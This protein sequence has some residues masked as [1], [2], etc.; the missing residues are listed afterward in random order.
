MSIEEKVGQLLIT[1]V[2]G[3]ELNDES[4]ALIKQHRIGGVIFAKENVIGEDQTKEFIRSFKRLSVENSEVPMFFALSETGG[5]RSVFP[6]TMKATQSPE[7]IGAIGD[8]EQAYTAGKQIADNMRSLGFNLNFAPVANM[9]FGTSDNEFEE[10]IFAGE[11]QP[12]A[13]MV[14]KFLQGLQEG[15]VFSAAKYFPANAEPGNPNLPA[16][17]EMLKNRE[18]VPFQALAENN[19]SM[20]L[21]SHVFVQTSDS[22]LPIS[23]SEKAKEELLEGFNYEGILIADDITKPIVADKFGIEQSSVMAIQSGCDMI[24]V[25]D[26]SKTA[27]VANRLVKAVNAGEISTETMNNAVFKV[28]MLKAKL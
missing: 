2:N 21:V 23:L 26:P 1:A 5:E 6:E 12:T 8:V 20:M 13:E 17:I 9:S 22:E 11:P 14:K 19:V 25:G 10:Q 4:I 27:S 7:Q 24:L 15:S 3:T 28:L 18:L 16:D